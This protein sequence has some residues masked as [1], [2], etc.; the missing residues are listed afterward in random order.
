MKTKMI[1]KDQKGGA[2][3]E[4]AIVLPLLVFLVVGIFEFGLFVY[5]QQVITNAS[6]VGVR[7]GIGRVDKDNNPITSTDIETIVN[8]YCQGELITFSIS[9]PSTSFPDG[10][11]IAGKTFQEDFSVKVT[12]NY[13]FLV[14][15][16]F[17]IG[18]TYKP[19]TGLTLMKMGP[20]PPAGS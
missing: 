10:T 20:V 19:L 9:S 11:N 18:N 5:N 14:P 2:V 3:V 12:Y 7:A 13:Y 16:L 17:S 8:T 1:I 4:F 15:S 6:R